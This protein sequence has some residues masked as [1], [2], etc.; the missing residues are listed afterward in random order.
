M[1][2]GVSGYSYGYYNKNYNKVNKGLNDGSCETAS[3]IAFKGGGSCET[4]SS[5]AFK[6]NAT[7]VVKNT[8]TKNASALKKF[9]K[10][11]LALI[12]GALGL[13]VA[14]KLTK[15]TQ[16]DKLKMYEAKYP[17]LMK[18]L[19][20]SDDCY[21]RDGDVCGFDP[22]YTDASKIAIFELFEKDPK[23]AYVLATR[24][25]K[26]KSETLSDGAIDIILNDYERLIKYPARNLNDSYLKSQL[27]S[28]NPLLADMAMYDPNSENKYANIPVSPQDLEVYSKY[29]TDEESAK[30][31]TEVVKSEHKYLYNWNKADT[32]SNIAKADLIKNHPTMS[33]ELKNKILDMSYSKDMREAVEKYADDS[34]DLVSFV[35]K[36]K[37]FGDAKDLVGYYSVAPAQFDVAIQLY[38]DPK[39]IKEFTKKMMMTSEL[40]GE[41]EKGN[42][43]IYEIKYCYKKLFEPNVKGAL[44][45]DVHTNIIVNFV[46]D[47]D[48]DKKNQF[49]RMIE[50]GRCKSI[51]EMEKLL[52][53]YQK[54]PDTEI[55]DK[56]IEQ[57]DDKLAIAMG[58]Y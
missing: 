7:Q 23:Q 20:D 40:F 39:E 14:Q 9:P 41:L 31:L 25:K 42:P 53:V 27:V 5:I 58:L 55:T 34:A 52:P 33:S 17:E 48:I 28:K 22:H 1:V 3:S 4:T 43:D 51:S 26:D 30:A 24:L 19:N 50:D 10:K 46:K 45:H 56:M 49:M 57:F 29:C 38:D 6:A 16:Q 47:M 44:K 2:N 18:V 13:G 32:E 54:N 37:T 36:Y 11:V 15:S 8:T 35:N 12:A 21:D